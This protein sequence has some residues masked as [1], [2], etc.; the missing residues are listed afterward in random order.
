MAVTVACY[1]CGASYA[2]PRQRCDCGEPLWVDGPAGD[3]WPA[4][5]DRGLWRYADWLP[6]ARPT[7]G[8]LPTAGGTPLFRAP[9]LDDYAGCR[10]SVKDETANPTGTFKDRGSAVGVAWA[11]G[12]GFDRVGTVSHG[13]M[14]TSMAA[15]A[16]ATGLDCLVLVPDDIPEARLAHVAQFSPRIVRVDGDYGR[17]YDETLALGPELG[18][19]FVNSDAPLRVAGQGTVAI[20]IAEAGAGAVPDAVVLPLSSGGNASGVWKALRELRAAGL[21]G[22]LPRL[23][24]V[25]AAVAAPVAEAYRAGRDRVTPVEPADTVAYSIGNADPPSGNRALAAARATD[26]GVLAV[27]D[28]AMLEARAELA[29]AAGLS[30]EPAS[31]ATL[32]GTR[33]LTRRGELAAD[34]EVVLVATGTGFREPPS[35]DA[36]VETVPLGSLREALRD[37]RSG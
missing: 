35:L 18:V 36:D 15:A 2:L 33:A 8:V 32:A 16:A 12:H 29:R 25:Q 7:D 5:S 27:S 22:A 1:G 26:G 34:D 19:H 37:G 31:A 28:E 10:V 4:S 14:A 13:N 23:Y 9:S 21:V 20:E 6:V 3:R 17:L 24:L 30:V 11:A